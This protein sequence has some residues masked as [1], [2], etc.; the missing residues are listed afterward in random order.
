MTPKRTFLSR[1]LILVAIAAILGALHIGAVALKP[2]LS[3]PPV[4]ATGD[5]LYA[6]N[7]DSPTDPDWEQYKGGQIA[8][9]Q[10]GVL[11]I[12]TDAVKSNIFAPLT[13]P[14]G[15]FDLR[16]T[17]RYSTGDVNSDPYSEYGVLFRLVDIRNYYLFRVR[18]DG[19]YRITRN[20]NG[21]QEDLSAAIDPSRAKSP[22][23]VGIGRYN[24]LRIVAKADQFTFYV[25][26]NPLT[27]CPKGSD[28][29]STWNG[30]KCASNNQQ[31]ADFLTDSTFRSG[32]IALAVYQNSDPIKVEFDQLILI[33][34]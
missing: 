7:F 6:T 31:T 4:L 17:T 27:L 1:L 10:N 11:E 34:P 22:Y 14:F 23:T 19:A 28:K 32:R 12:G 33:A 26:G 15:D 20:L 25:N 30:E 8:Q 2:V 29:R 5:V 16:V 3:A 24:D 13:Y 9:I 21:V 18:A